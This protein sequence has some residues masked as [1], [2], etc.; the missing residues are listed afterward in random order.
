MFVKTFEKNSSK[1]T[2]DKISNVCFHKV[3][4][5]YDKEVRIIILLNM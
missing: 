5:Y 4:C 1:Y 2:L 3:S